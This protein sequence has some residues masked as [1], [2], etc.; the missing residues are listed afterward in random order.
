M[1]GPEHIKYYRWFEDM[2]EKE[3]VVNWSEYYAIPFRKNSTY[4][5]YYWETNFM[6]EM[7][8]KRNENEL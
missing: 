5:F 4:M 7:R 8:L 1:I 6:T 2:F 3:Y